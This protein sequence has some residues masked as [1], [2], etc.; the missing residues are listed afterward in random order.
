[1]ALS[2]T[3]VINKALGLLGANS[4]ADPD[5]NSEGARRAKGVYE[6]VIRAALEEHAWYFAKAGASLP[7][8]AA[9]PAFKYAYAYNL[10]SDFIRLVEVEGQWVFTPPPVSVGLPAP[11]ELF[12]R[13][14][15]TDLEAPLNI[16]YLKDVVSDPT[17]WT[18]LFV[19]V[20]AADLAVSLAMPLTKELSKQDAALKYRE[21]CL[22]RAKHANA[23]Q[24]PPDYIS[25]GSWVT[26][27]LGA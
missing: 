27:R 13:Q 26:A 7:A 16:F 19:E 22:R 5:E 21:L 1:M 20:A 23:I 2:R 24:R 3:E 14:I 15:R 25:D 18:P 6:T 9:A 12:Q 8:L 4:I 11:F 10:P 17:I